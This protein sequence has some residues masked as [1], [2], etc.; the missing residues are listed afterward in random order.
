MGCTLSQVILQ[1][2]TAPEVTSI[3][4]DIYAPTIAKGLLTWSQFECVLS[5]HAELKAAIMR[6]GLGT[7]N[8]G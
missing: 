6:H 3:C 4:H 1:E 7:G 5:V 8:D 2:P